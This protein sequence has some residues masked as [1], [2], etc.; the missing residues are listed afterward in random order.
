MLRSSSLPARGG[1]WAPLTLGQVDRAVHGR[2]GDLLAVYRGQGGEGVKR[3]GVLL[4]VLW[5]VITQ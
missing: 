4:V 1:G 3:C 2:T 5:V